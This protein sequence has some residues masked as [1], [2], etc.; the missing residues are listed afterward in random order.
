MMNWAAFLRRECQKYHYKIINNSHI[1][2]DQ[3]FQLFDEWLQD[4]LFSQLNIPI[5]IGTKLISTQF[6]EYENLFIKVVEPNGW[7]NRTFHLGNTMSI[8]LPSAERYAE[9]VKIEHQWLPKLSSK[10]SISIPKPIAMGNPSKDYPW[11]WSIYSWI[12]GK[13]AHLLNL[14]ENSLE[15]IALQLACFLNE[16]ESIDSSNGPMPGK[17]NFFRGDSLIVYN[18]ET[19]SIIEVL[20]DY[21]NVPAAIKI[22]ETAISSKWDKNPVWIH[23]DFSSSNI[24]IKN[25][26]LVGVIDFGGMAIGDPSCDLVIAWTFLK[27][28]SREK[29]KPSLDLDQNT[30]NR[31]KGWALWKALITLEKISDK[32]SFQST[33]QLSIIDE[34]LNIHK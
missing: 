2:I 1:T 17:H 21:I 4:H 10:L 20:K 31:A 26:Q 30:W 19:R 24:L 28:K 18:A 9:K 8:R 5:E 29:F 15:D 6:P 7:D 25:N 11:N 23:G 34:I 12:E 3:T 33:E 13:S 14:D 16:L 27:K 32:K 22:W